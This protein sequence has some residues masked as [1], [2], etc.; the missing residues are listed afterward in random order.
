MLKRNLV[1]LALMVLPVFAINY[2]NDATAK[3]ERLNPQH[4]SSQIQDGNPI[5][6]TATESEL[7]M[8]FHIDKEPLLIL[9]VFIAIFACY[10]ILFDPPESSDW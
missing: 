4:T 8:S 6:I 7:N 10:V 3:Y 1:G 5:R 9:N 2:A